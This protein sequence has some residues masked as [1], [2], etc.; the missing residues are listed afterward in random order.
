MVKRLLSK[1]I[2]LSLLAFSF[3]GLAVS[4]PEKRDIA[5]PVEGAPFEFETF[6][7][8]F[9]VKDE[10][11]VSAYIKNTS[12]ETIEAVEVGFAFYDY[13]NEFVYGFRGMSKLQ[14]VKFQL[15]PGEQ[16]LIQFLPRFS[17]SSFVLTSIAFASKAR[18]AGG[19]VWTANL[20]NVSKS[21]KQLAG[22]GFDYTKLEP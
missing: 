21:I 17:K 22:V 16:T 7:A 1:S 10:F 15:A 8:N 13:F 9:N 12:K 18:L 2:I 3:L 14:S 20:E 5:I 4:A 6:G 19:K 11:V